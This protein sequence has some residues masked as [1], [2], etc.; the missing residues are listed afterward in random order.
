MVDSFCFSQ[1]Y[2]REGSS[3]SQL[4]SFL[5]AALYRQHCRYLHAR[6]AFLH[7]GADSTTSQQ[8]C[9]KH[10]S[11]TTINS[12]QMCHR[13][14]IQKWNSTQ[15]S[16]CEFEQKKCK[17]HLLII[18]WFS[19]SPGQGATTR[20]T[21]GSCLHLCIRASY[22]NYWFVPKEL[23]RKAHSNQGQYFAHAVLSSELQ[24]TL[25]GAGKAGTSPSCSTRGLSPEVPNALTQKETQDQK[26]SDYS[27][28]LSR[29]LWYHKDNLKEEG[30]SPWISMRWPER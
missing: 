23:V 4:H 27:S 29:N 13:V 5:P 25:Q 6:T 1:N 9:L 15:N 30:D 19:R 8:P 10:Q 14:L 11:W 18:S 17:W 12:A 21:R 24:Y 2:H 3:A 22:R 16:Q 20:R 26:V 7:S 28:L